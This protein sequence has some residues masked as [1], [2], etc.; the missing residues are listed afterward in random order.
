M[1]LYI[2]NFIIFEFL[3]L[4]YGKIDTNIDIVSFV[5]CSRINTTG[6]G[7]RDVRVT[8]QV[9]REFYVDTFIIFG[10]LSLEYGE[11]DTRIESVSFVS[12]EM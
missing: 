9:T 12:P 8:F 1:S 11:I 6:H 2:N 3:G 5:I 4:E 10:F 7:N